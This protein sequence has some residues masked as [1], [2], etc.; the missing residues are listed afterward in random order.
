MERVNTLLPRLDGAIF[1][2]FGK[3]A[4]PAQSAARRRFLTS[5]Q[6]DI[7]LSTCRISEDAEASGT[8]RTRIA[9]IPIH[10]NGNRGSM[11]CYLVAGGNELAP[12]TQTRHK[13]EMKK[14][15]VFKTCMK[16]A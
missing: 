4:A 11:T 15:K 14:A 1:G 7:A 2:I 9:W 6:L 3:G 13:E 12:V 5:R 16:T 10:A 8:M